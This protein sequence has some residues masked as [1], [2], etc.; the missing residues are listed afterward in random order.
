MKRIN[1][2][3]IFISIFFCSCEKDPFENVIFSNI[4][5][6]N[7]SSEDAITIKSVSVVKYDINPTT[8]DTMLVKFE[9]DLSISEK[10]FETL[11][12]TKP[13]SKVTSEIYVNEIEYPITIDPVSKKTYIYKGYN[14]FKNKEN[15]IV[16]KFFMYKDEI[17]PQRRK[18][19]S[20]TFHFRVN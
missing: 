9:L 18:N 8:K 3:I 7:F 19:A 2:Y 10:Y 20:N 13:L 5:S 11:D 12:I 15:D 16:F 14:L 6:D 17:D 1:L 4:Y